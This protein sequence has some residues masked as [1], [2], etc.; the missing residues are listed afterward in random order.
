MAHGRFYWNELITRD[1]EAA[2]AFFAD[3]LG[4]NYEPFG[5]DYWVIMDGGDAVGGI[6]P[7]GEG[8]EDAPAERWV[9]Y[10]AVDDVD[11][12]LKGVGKAGGQVLREPFDIP[13]VGRIAMIA[14]RSGAVLGWITPAP[15]EEG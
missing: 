3:T 10:V 6:M 4:W 14:D 1:A 7:L 8:M 13:Q 5:D 15:R 2:K 12:R 11:A 9:S